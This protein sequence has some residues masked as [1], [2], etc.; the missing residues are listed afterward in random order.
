MPMTRGKGKRCHLCRK[1]AS[2]QH[3]FD[4]HYG[5][6]RPFRVIACGRKHLEELKDIVAKTTDEVAGDA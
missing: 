2:G 3:S 4:Y 6:P 5:D 1:L